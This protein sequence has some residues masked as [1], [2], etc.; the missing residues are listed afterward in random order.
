MPGLN[1][2]DP[3]LK[4]FHKNDTLSEL[5]FRLKSENVLYVKKYADSTFTTNL[6][7]QYELT[8]KDK[9]EVIDSASM[10]FTDYGSNKIKKSLEGKISLPTVV[11]KD[12]Y[13]KVRIT[14]LNRDHFIRKGISINRTNQSNSQ[15]FLVLDSNKNVVFD[16]YFKTGNTV[17]IIKGESNV[18]ESIT[19][20]YYKSDQPIAR[21]PYSVKEESKK[22]KE[23]KEENTYKPASVEK[24]TFAADKM[25][26]YTIDKKGI[27]FF[28]S[29]TESKEGITFFNFEDN[30]PKVKSIDNM[31]GAMR[32]FTT[33]KEFTAITDSKD[34][35]EALENFWIEK[36]GS[37]ERARALIREY[38]NRVEKANKYFTSYQ[39]GWKTDRGIIYI[40]YGTPNIVYKNKKYENWIYGEE[41]NMLSLN[42][43]FYNVKNPITDNDFSLSRSPIF[44]T[45]WYRAV[46]I[47]R[48]GR[49]Y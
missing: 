22:E 23:E 36:A 37:K 28:Q 2:L 24:L 34:K 7:I 42:F 8:G 6:L 1:L 27:Y 40:I 38:Y 12:L 44:K 45:S 17:T 29:D 39:E 21:P 19:L 9:K 20:K 5:Y 48:S 4:V 13:L 14:D 32:Y 47:W 46:D 10:Y 18:H 3:E 25:L 30:F 41:N 43:I 33:K 11:G 26:T 35:K 16:R 15:N 49:V 31:I